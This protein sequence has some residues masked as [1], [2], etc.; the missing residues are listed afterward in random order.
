MLMKILSPDEIDSLL[1]VRPTDA[2]PLDILGYGYTTEGADKF[3][4]EQ[5]NFVPQIA[6]YVH[7]VLESVGIFPPDIDLA[8]AG[9]RTFIRKTG[10][11][12]EVSSMEEIGS[13]RFERF[14]TGPFSEQEAVRKY[15]ERVTN[16]DYIQYKSKNIPI[17]ETEFLNRSIE[18][19]IVYW[20]VELST[21][22][23]TE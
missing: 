6:A 11:V 5:P 18:P 2:H 17:V 7:R 20:F 13:S 22:P 21:N 19:R 10:K 1:E 12:F 16:P 9:Y 15:I 8:A 14:A 23:P 3:R 4:A